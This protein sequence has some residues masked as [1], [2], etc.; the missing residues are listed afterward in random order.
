MNKVYRIE[1]LPGTDWLVGTCYCGAVREVDDPVVMWQW[2]LAH[3]EGH[4]RGVAELPVRPREV[5][6]A[7]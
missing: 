5:V 1:W 2:L 3:P 7:G 6:R 4:D